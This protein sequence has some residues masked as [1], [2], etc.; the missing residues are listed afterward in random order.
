MKSSDPI[1]GTQLDKEAAE[2]M[3]VRAAYLTTVLKFS[4][5]DAQR[6]IRSELPNKPWLKKNPK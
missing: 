4:A 6:Q 1:P 2:W 5:I 3:K